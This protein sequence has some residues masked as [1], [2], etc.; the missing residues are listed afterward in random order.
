MFPPI[1]GQESHEE[2]A[3]L[4]K[5]GFFTQ[6]YLPDTQLCRRDRLKKDT[7]SPISRRALPTHAYQIHYFSLKPTSGKLTSAPVTSFVMIDQPPQKVRLHASFIGGLRI[8]K[9]PS[10]SLNVSFPFAFLHFEDNALVFGWRFFCLKKSHTLPYGE[11]FHIRLTNGLF[12]RGVQIVHRRAVLP[13][14]LLF[15][16]RRPKVIAAIFSAHGIAGQ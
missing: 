10:A 12:S 1:L 2:K 16:H 9:F 4:W 8:G 7:P 15:L 11:I 6:A 3:I 13:A 14:Y 5:N